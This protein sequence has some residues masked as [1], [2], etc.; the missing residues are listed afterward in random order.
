MFSLIFAIFSRIISNSY[1]NVFQKLLTNLGL[2]SSIVCFYSYLGLSI[3][4]LV[5]FIFTGINFS[6][7]I[8]LNTLI[9][10]SL[11]ALG[12][13]FIIKALSLGEL[14]SLA[15]INSYKPIVA[16]FVAFLYLKEIPSLIAIFGIILIIYGTFFIYNKT[17]NTN[18]KAIVYRVLALILSGTEAVFIKKIILL[19]NVTSAFFLWA[20]SGLIFSSLFIISKEK[21]SFKIPS[22]KY[23]F[24]LLLSVGVMQYTTNYVF[25]KMNTSYALALFQLSTLFSVL[26]G[27]NIFKEKNLKRKIIGSIFMILGAIIIILF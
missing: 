15:P 5:Y 7:E 4:G 8:F 6:T 11:G 21:T 18:K 24:L 9:I 27:A 14:S 23:L 20:I 3:L 1:I 26:L 13:Y 17:E 22:F 25:A 19:S 10:G 16:M 12:N 2:T